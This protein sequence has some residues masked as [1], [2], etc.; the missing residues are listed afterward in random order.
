MN[1][2]KE[3]YPNKRR[4]A[5]KITRVAFGVFLVGIT[6][7]LLNYNRE[8]VPQ[9]TFYLGMAAVVA[10]IVLEIILHRKFR[11]NRTLLKVLDLVGWIVLGVLTYL[12]A[13]N[14]LP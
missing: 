7:L 9:R 3:Q 4:L 13:I 6:L 1:A 10:F 8:N 5:G 12:I 14:T 11:E 2:T